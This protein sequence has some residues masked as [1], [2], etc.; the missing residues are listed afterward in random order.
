VLDES[1]LAGLALG[2]GP[3]SAALTFIGAIIFLPYGVSRARQ[4]QIAEALRARRE[5]AAVVSAGHSS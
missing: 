5:G 2:W 3:L 4:A 1:V